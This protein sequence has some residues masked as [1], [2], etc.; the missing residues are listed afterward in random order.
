MINL[1]FSNNGSKSSRKYK[2]RK[3]KIK[4]SADEDNSDTLN[5][6]K[7]GSKN[8]EESIVSKNIPLPVGPPRIKFDSV[9]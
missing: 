2:N 8:E 4:R 7:H 6:A 5:L 9:S 1:F 3:N